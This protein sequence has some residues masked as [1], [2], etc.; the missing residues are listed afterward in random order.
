MKI[1]QEVNAISQTCDMIHI[2]QI[3]LQKFY[4]YV[5]RDSAPFLYFV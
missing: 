4:V 5:P 2:L 3:I 1:N